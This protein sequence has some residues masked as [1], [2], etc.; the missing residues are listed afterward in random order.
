MI[1]AIKTDT[2]EAELWLHNDTSQKA[3][4]SWTANRQLAKDL[5]RECDA[6]LQHE[7]LAW[8]DLAG[9]IVF[10]GPGSFTGLRIG[11][12]S[13]MS[14]AHSLDI[15]SVGTNGNAWITDGINRLNAG[16]SDKYIQP[17]YGSEPHIT[18]PRK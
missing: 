7:S 1:L 6:F 11:I 4:H 12:V 17:H 5:L 16:E 14:M 2:P 10:T 15:P 8:K 13:I 3:H 18:A 9:L